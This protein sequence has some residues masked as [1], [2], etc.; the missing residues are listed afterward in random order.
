[1]RNRFGFAGLKLTE[2]EDDSHENLA[3]LSKDLLA[4][5]VDT[6]NGRMIELENTNHIVRPGCDAT[7]DKQTDHARDHAENIEVERN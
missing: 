2:N 3:G 4:D 1:M 5:I 7:N 6:I